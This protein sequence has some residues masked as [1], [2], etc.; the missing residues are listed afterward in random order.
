MAKLQLESLPAEGLAKNLVAQTD[1][2]N[3]HAGCHQ[4]A[5]GLHRIP[6]C[7]R[8][9]RAVGQENARWLIPRRV[10]GGG[11]CWH[12]L[13]PEPL[14]PEPAQDVVFHP[15]IVGDDG[16]VRL[17]QRLART[18]RKSGGWGKR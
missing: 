9:A 18:D 17:W 1:P 3:R 4:V 5:H 10:R 8:V 6:E 13:D 14:L 2:K 11:C 12:D 16:D 7:R 15:E